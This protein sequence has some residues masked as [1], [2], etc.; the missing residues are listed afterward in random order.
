MKHYLKLYIAL[1][2]LGVYSLMAYRINFINNVLSDIFYSTL[3][4]LSIILLTSRTSSVFGWTRYELLLLT[5]IYNVVF[6]IFY[7]LFA[8]NFEDMAKIINRGELDSWLLK[9]VDTQFG[10]SLW[11]VKYSNIFR[12]IIASIF[13]FFVLPL[14]HIMPSIQTLV[15]FLICMFLSI[16]LIYSITFF[17]MTFLIWFTNLN[18]LIELLYFMNGITRFPREMYHNTGVF[19][20]FFLFPLTLVVIVPTQVLLNKASF[21]EEIS[22]LFAS[23]TAFY[24]SRK[25]FKFALRF[26]TSASG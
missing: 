11:K 24:L 12:T 8:S 17:I 3:T 22:L 19:L 5:A 9:P 21:V 1:L 26:Y 23:I 4:I 16:L 20:F 14:V 2:R 13:I 7:I 18:N 25:F 6:G 10:I 15:S